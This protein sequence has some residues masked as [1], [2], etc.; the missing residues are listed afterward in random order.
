MKSQKLS[1]LTSFGCKNL[2]VSHVMFDS[3]LLHS[4]DHSD[5]NAL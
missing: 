2:L 4:R 3:C 5:V 1:G